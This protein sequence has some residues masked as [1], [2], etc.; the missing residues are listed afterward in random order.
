MHREI[1]EQ[2]WDVASRLSCHEDPASCAVEF[3]RIASATSSSA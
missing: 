1:G 2:V 3:E